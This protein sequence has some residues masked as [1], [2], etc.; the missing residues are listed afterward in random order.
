MLADID[1]HIHVVRLS[2]ITNTD[3]L[4]QTCEDHLEILDALKRR[5]RS[6]AVMALRR[7]IEWGK[8]NVET[9]IRDALMRAHL[10]V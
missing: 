10:A 8:T 5:D 1:S 2:D 4:R 9:A 6:A 3:R 7:N